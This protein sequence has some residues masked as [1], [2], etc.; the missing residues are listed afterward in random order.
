MPRIAVLDDYQNVARGFADW[1]RLPA[2]WTLDV[3]N[4]QIVGEAAVAEAL[5]PYEVV[6]VMRERTPLPASLIDRLPNLRLIVTSGPRNQSIDV[7]AA[8]AKGI[9]VC[10]T[11]SL[12]H[13]PMEIAWA[14]IF[15]LMR[16]VPREDR[17]LREG[18]WQ[19]TVGRGLKGRLL[20]LVGLGKLGSAMVPAAKAF[21]MRVVAWSQNLT[22]ERAA[23]V[24]VERVDKDTLF[25]ESEIVSIH[26]LL[27]PR[28]RGLIG[29]R[30]IGL[31]RRDA[32]LVNTSR[33][34][35]VDEAALIDALRNGRIAGA[36]LDVFDQEPLPSDHPLLKL[37]NTVLTPHLGYVTEEN[38]RNYYNQGLEDILAWIEGKP[39]RVIQPPP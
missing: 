10:G 12:A 15:S 28:T 18:R 24:G 33:G 37:E 30:E 11:D 8:A 32:Y 19:L 23:E 9:T 21:G 17:A 25:R 20:G 16:Q 22:A 6:V 31:M 29:A 27:S 14:L 4:R 38:Y 7:K 36:G 35:I 13:P 39:I 1:A 26:L 3:F 34:P 2:G 5:A